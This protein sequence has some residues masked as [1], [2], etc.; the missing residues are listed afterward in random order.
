MSTRD[1][2]SIELDGKTYT[3]NVYT[4]GTRRIF[5]TIWYGG[6]SKKDTHAYR[7]GDQLEMTRVAKLILLELI[8]E[9]RHA[10]GR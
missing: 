5:Q 4:D 1:E 8:R 2:I 9:E 10:D 6:R 7:P 3:A